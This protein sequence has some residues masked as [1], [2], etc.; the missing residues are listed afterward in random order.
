[1]RLWT[2]DICDAAKNRHVEI[3]T[4]MQAFYGHKRRALGHMDAL[5]RQVIRVPKPLPQ[6]TTDGGEGADIENATTVETPGLDTESG[7]SGVDDA[8][9]S[10]TALDIPLGIDSSQTATS[11]GN[12]TS[13]WI[14]DDPWST[15][16]TTHMVDHQSPLVV[17]PPLRPPF[18]LEDTDSLLS[19]SP[20]EESPERLATNDMHEPSWTVN[21]SDND[22]TVVDAV[23]GC[24]VCRGSPLDPIVHILCG[25]VFCRSCAMEELAKT[26]QCPSCDTAIFAPLKSDIVV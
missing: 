3:F 11:E 15:D 16:V 2:C 17:P 20:W 4:T 26:L 9:P 12:A 7:A 13:T 1:M 23:V 5:A 22:T 24:G 6:I 21:N 18:T 10:S 19:S 25:H 14:T 8:L